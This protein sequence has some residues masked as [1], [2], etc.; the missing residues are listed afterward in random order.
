MEDLLMVTVTV[1][2]IPALLYLKTRIKG[3]S[4]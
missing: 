4:D 1:E 2:S 3:I